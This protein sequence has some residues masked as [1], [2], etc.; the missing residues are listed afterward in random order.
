MTDKLE[1]VDN[2]SHEWWWEFRDSGAIKVWD[3]CCVDVM[4]AAT[5]AAALEATRRRDEAWVEC[6]SYILDEKTV[7][8]GGKRVIQPATIRALIKE[9]SND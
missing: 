4:E 6:L 2:W 8:I 9:L 5:K 7:K 1:W 3:L